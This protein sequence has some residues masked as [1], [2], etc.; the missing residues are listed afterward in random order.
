MVGA[1]DGIQRPLFCELIAIDLEWR[2]AQEQPPNITDLLKRFPARHAE[3]QNAFSEVESARVEL[4][5]RSNSNAANS[6]GHAFANG[7]V[8]AERYTL[9]KII[10]EGGMGTVYLAEQYVPMKRQVAL[11]VIKSGMDSKSVI[12]RFDAERQALAMMDHP[13]IAKVYDGGT[14]ASG[15][16]YFAMEY[17][18][19]YPITQ[20]CDRK[21][22]SV[23]DRL[24]LF[25][26]VIEAV[27]HAHTKGII[28]RDIKPANVLVSEVDG[29]FVPKVIDFGVAKAIEQKLTDQSVGSTAFIVGTPAYMSPEQADPTTVDIDTRTD[30]YSLG[31]I[32]FELVAGSPPHEPRSTTGGAVAEL[33]RMVRDSDSPRPSSKLSVAATLPDIAANRNIEPRKLTQMLRSELDWIVLKA[34]DRDRSQRYETAN[35]FARDIQRYLAG[36][37]VD[38]QPPS[39]SYRLRKIVVRY[40]RYVIAAGLI[41]LALVGGIIGTTWGLLEAK[42]QEQFAIAETK[43]KELALE[44][45]VRE[46]DYAE[47]LADFVSR[48]LLALTTLEGR[49]DFD[50]A[51]AGLTKES[52]LADL[53]DRAATKLDQRKDLEP[54]TEARLRWMIGRSL[55][56]QGEYQKSINLYQR[57]YELYSQ[58]LGPN[59]LLTLASQEGLIEALQKNGKY[60]LASPLI[61]DSLNRKTRLFGQ[62]HLETLKSISLSAQNVRGLGKPSDAVVL[63]ERTLELRKKLLGP[64]EQDTLTNMYDLAIAYIDADQRGKA[65]PLVEQTLKLQSIT[66]GVDHPDTNTCMGLLARLHREAGEFDQAI[67]LQEREVEWTKAHYGAGHPKD[68]FATAAL[69]ACYRDSGRTEKAIEMFEQALAMVEKTF[70]TEHPN[71]ANAMSSL[72]MSY[73]A[74]NDHS[75]ALPLFE[76][77]LELR[78]KILGKEHP[79]TLNSMLNVASCYRSMNRNAEADEMNNRGLELAQRVL[80]EDHNTTLT[81]MQNIAVNHWKAKRLDLSIPLMEKVLAGKEAKNGRSHPDTLLAIANLGTNYRDAGRH[82]ESI[83][84]LEEAYA[85]SGNNPK[86][87]FI[88]PALLDAYLRAEKIEEANGLLAKLVAGVREANSFTGMQLAEKLNAVGQVLL[89]SERF[90]EAESLLRESM[91]LRTELEPDKWSTFSG[92]SSVGESL[93]GQG[94]HVDAEPLLLAGYEGMKSR[95][96]DQPSSSRIQLQEHLAKTIEHY[97]KLQMPMD[98]NKWE[99]FRIELETLM[100]KQ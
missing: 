25:V 55:Y 33:L 96:L 58:T 46:R 97:A 99:T 37:I 26:R 82:D 3:I 30:V 85:S 52:T 9:V 86:L 35:S 22:L 27:Q 32:L 50:D 18:Q 84:L 70:G 61:E 81:L 66:L 7:T 49:L 23:P 56:Y 76:K 24:E 13:N 79:F 42:K 1:E 88:G 77:T 36:E 6:S 10:G 5:N 60:Q 28:H 21:Q 89:R 71:S 41:V 17:V 44:N 91:T 95:M 94:K 12:A 20:F 100:D 43:K 78:A 62:D 64:E 48:D 45:V 39:A 34:L 40:K 67:L 72:A 15:Q 47:A 92:I 80:G 54:Q 63:F 98:A 2:Y 73:R 14:T 83:K 75:R 57:S 53:V 74:A 38:A 19:G 69:A 11:K 59:D 68:I 16:P 51:G 65:K 87:E 8:I 31:V 29:R 4:D 90:A 93:L